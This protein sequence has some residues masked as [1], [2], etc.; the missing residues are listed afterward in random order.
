MKRLVAILAVLCLLLTFG[1]CKKE[2]EKPKEN[3]TA[4]EWQVDLQ[5]HWHETENG[6]RTDEAAHT[7]GA[8]NRCTVCEAQITRN[9]DGSGSVVV[10]GEE[11][12]WSEAIYYDADGNVMSTMRTENTYDANGNTLT[13]TYY[14]DGLLSQTEIYAYG[15]GGTTYLCEVTVYDEKGAKEVMT[16]AEN[17]ALTSLSKYDES[18]KRVFWEYYELTYDG[19]GNVIHDKTY[20][21]GVLVLENSY[22]PN[23][24]GTFVVV[25]KIEYDQDGK[26][27]VTRYG[28]D[29]AV[30]GTTTGTAPSEWHT[31]ITTVTTAVPITTAPTSGQK[32]TVKTTASTAW[33]TQ[34]T[35]AP[36]T[37][38][39]GATTT[40]STEE[41]KPTTTTT[42]YQGGIV[43]DDEKG[44]VV[45]G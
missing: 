11:N 3:V 37:P 6:K 35:S 43:I 8:D 23:A 29:G 38:S 41:A 30:V 13:S 17:E 12:A 39:A 31:T 34:P 7:L 44:D 42:A 22:A 36:T 18:G 14:K 15:T 40:T 10:F 32:T 24:S 4:G 2:E 16:Y 27:T 25:E 1:A 26:M 19:E 33:A 45:I 9:E 5:N 20:R 28:V 21:D